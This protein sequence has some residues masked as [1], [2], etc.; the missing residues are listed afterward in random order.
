MLGPRVRHGARERH[1]LLQHRKLVIHR[2]AR[3]ARQCRGPRRQLL[4]EF[5]AL[6]GQQFDAVGGEQLVV[7]DRGRDRAGARPRGAQ[8]RLHVV[9]AGAAGLERIDPHRLLARQ[10]RGQRVAGIGALELD[11]GG[12]PLRRELELLGGGFQEIG[13]HRNRLALARRLLFLRLRI[14]RPLRPAIDRRLRQHIIVERNGL[15]FPPLGVAALSFLRD[16]RPIGARLL[17]ERGARFLIFFQLAAIFGD[18]LRRGRLRHRIGGR[19]REYVRIH[20]HGR[21]A[22]EQRE[23]DKSGT[24]ANQWQAHGSVVASVPAKSAPKGCD[25]SSLLPLW[26][27]VRREA[28]RM[29][30]LSA[31]L[32]RLRPLPRGEGR[33]ASLLLDAAGFH[34]LRPLLLILVDEVGIVFRRAGRDLGAVIAQLL[35][36]LVGGERVAQR[37][38]ELVDDRPR[39]AWLARRGR[40][41]AKRRSRTGPLRSSSARRATGPSG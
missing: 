9:I 5:V 36:H 3:R 38:V 1:H 11:F 32:M 34:E 39:R 28:E 2:L 25:F 12:R 13:D 17:L 10:A 29:R 6:F 23:R 40:N 14:D 18:R 41:R 26:E 19:G 4:D 21:R 20:R 35:L 33:D 24:H 37:L 15:A 8:A 27:K 30:G 7:A 16:R 31:R 22:R